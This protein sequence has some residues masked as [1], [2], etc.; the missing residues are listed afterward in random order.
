MHF[1]ADFLGEKMQWCTKNVKYQVKF[2]AN[3]LK[4]TK[5][6]AEVFDVWHNMI[7]LSA[8]KCMLQLKKTNLER[9]YLMSIQKKYR[10][11]LERWEI[12]LFNWSGKGPLLSNWGFHVGQVTHRILYL[13][14]K[15][16]FLV[17]W[18]R[19]KDWKQKRNISII[20]ECFE[21]KEF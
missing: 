10:G 20:Q 7:H 11:L 4:S 17:L 12:Q 18:S 3:M 14:E 15:I 8:D 16:F 13:D 2:F 19:F 21:R 1:L 6:E 5:I 9:L